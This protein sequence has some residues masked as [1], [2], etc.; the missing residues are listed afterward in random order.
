M[1]NKEPMTID[2]IDR[3][4]EQARHANAGSAER[5]A[6]VEGLLTRDDREAVMYHFELLRDRTNEALYRALRAC[7]DQHGRMAA[8]VARD[9]FLRQRSPAMRADA[10]LVLG[11]MR[12]KQARQ[13]ALEVIEA[14]DEELRHA[15]CVVLGWVGTEQDVETVLRERLLRDPSA[16]VR[17]EAASAYREIWSRVPEV[18]EAAERDLAEALAGEEDEGA[19]ARVVGA[20]QAMSDAAGKRS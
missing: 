20:L 5:E 4:Y 8:V 12:S 3:L 16:R 18:K 15:A 13:L 6:L 9:V 10:L 14:E 2:D 17:G 11:R 7:F 1:S 19:A